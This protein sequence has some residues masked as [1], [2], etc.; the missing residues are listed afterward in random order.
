MHRGFPEGS[1]SASSL[2]PSLSLLLPSGLLPSG[3]TLSLCSASLEQGSSW[4]HC[5]QDQT[6]FRPC[7]RSAGRGEEPWL[8]PASCADPS[9]PLA[10]HALV[11]APLGVPTPGEM[12]PL[13]LLYRGCVALLPAGREVRD[14]P[15]VLSRAPSPTL[16]SGHCGV[17]PVSCC[18]G[19]P[20]CSP[21]V[22]TGFLPAAVQALGEDGPSGGSATTPGLH[23]GAVCP[24]SSHWQG[25][26]LV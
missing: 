16:A 3:L 10:A 6:T 8:S 2:L 12:V 15:P 23:S 24:N 9:P 4:C 25:Y 22:L 7:R 19:A 21:L 26:P 11:G 5:L 17:S 14:P 13:Q 20:I 1:G 18:L